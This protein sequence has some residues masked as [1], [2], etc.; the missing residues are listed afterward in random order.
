MALEEPGIRLID[1]RLRIRAAVLNIITGEANA[2]IDM[3]WIG[4]PA[5]RKAYAE[6]AIAARDLVAAEEAFDAYC[7]EARIFL[8]L[9]AGKDSSDGN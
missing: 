7:E 6:Q 4:S 2:C 8:N 5:E 3:P 9:P 1:A